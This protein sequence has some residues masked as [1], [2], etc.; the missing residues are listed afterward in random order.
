VGAVLVL[1]GRIRGAVAV[2]T[3]QRVVFVQFELPSSGEVVHWAWSGQP[4]QA[5]PNVTRRLAVMFLVT[6]F[7][8]VAVPAASSTVKSS[9]VNPPSMAGRS[10]HG[11]ITG[12]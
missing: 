9:R 10:G 5:A 1:E 11:L 7:G 4:V 8:Q 12:V 6:P 3:L 2:L